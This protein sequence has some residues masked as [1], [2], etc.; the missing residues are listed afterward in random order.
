MFTCVLLARQNLARPCSGEMPKLFFVVRLGSERKCILKRLRRLE[1][2]TSEADLLATE[3]YLRKRLVAVLGK[4]KANNPSGTNI[5]VDCKDCG[6]K[7][8]P[9]EGHAP[10]HLREGKGGKLVARSAVCAACLWAQSPK[11]PMEK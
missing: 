9:E 3:D 10:W 7:R 6:G 4:R 11:E 1:E 5:P 8:P 2:K